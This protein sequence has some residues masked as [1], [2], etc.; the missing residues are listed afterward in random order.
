M[1]RRQI[2]LGFAFLILAASG[3]FAEE[4]MLCA[5]SSEASRALNESLAILR[6]DT[7]KPSP[8]FFDRDSEIFSELTSKHWNILEDRRIQVDPRAAL[9]TE[10]NEGQ[11]KSFEFQLNE[12]LQKIASKTDPKLILAISGH[13]NIGILAQE[14]GVEQKEVVRIPY[15]ELS[16]VI[17]RAVRRAKIPNL[18]V[19]IVINACYSGSWSTDMEKTFCRPNDYKVYAWFSSPPNKEAAGSRHPYAL[20]DMASARAIEDG[21]GAELSPDPKRDLPRFYLYENSNSHFFWTNDSEIKSTRPSRPEE[22]E[23]AFLGPLKSR[24]LKLRQATA[25]SIR[26]QKQNGF[27]VTERLL[28][29]LQRMA[30]DEPLLYSKL[31]AI[32]TLNAYGKLDEASFQSL[33]QFLSRPENY[34]DRADEPKMDKATA[35]R[36]RE[37]DWGIST[38]ARSPMRFSAPFFAEEIEKEIRLG[39]TSNLS[40]QR[41]R[42][43]TLVE[44]L[45]SQKNPQL[46][47]SVRIALHKLRGELWRERP[48][49][50]DLHEKTIM[51]L[52]E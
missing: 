50:R 12:A 19:D 35:E 18:K 41:G 1:R 14:E 49:V 52:T 23:K 33:A 13:G 30:T 6:W 29:E 31:I 38:I 40:E 2:L 16:E 28:K 24:N 7:F 48:Q 8:F 4:R 45:R 47:A 25:D 43:W 10:V 42:L 15:A 17:D 3:S 27:V 21:P 46:R 32:D 11:I 9:E 39:L 22:F 51:S 44:N 34:F 37:Y 20:R 5:H 26:Y 36:A